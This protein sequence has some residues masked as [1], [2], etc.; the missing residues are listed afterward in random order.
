MIVTP[1]APSPASSAR[2]IG[3]AP[4]QRGRSDAWTLMQ[5]WRGHPS[6]SPGRISP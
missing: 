1:V 6:T 2:S 4:R 3:A 5:P